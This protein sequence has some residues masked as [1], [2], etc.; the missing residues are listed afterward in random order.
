[1]KKSILLIAIALF[2]GL[3]GYAQPPAGDAKKGDSYGEK[4][5]DKGAISLAELGKQLDKKDSVTAKIKGKVLEVCSK[6]GCWVTMELPNKSQMMVKFKDYAYFV[7]TSLSGKTVVLDGVARK[8]IVSVNELK[9]FAEDAKKPQAEI[10]AITKPEKQ[11]KFEA[12]GVL[13][14]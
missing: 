3:S 13:V 12:S 10:D 14:I 7:P 1:M 9:H 6:K 5:T 2:V 4:I 8:K 11:V